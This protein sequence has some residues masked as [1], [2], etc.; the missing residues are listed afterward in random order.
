MLLDGQ[1]AA[2]V[3]IGSDDLTTFQGKL[4]EELAD[5]GN[6]NLINDLP[7]VSGQCGSSLE[8]VALRQQAHDI[9]AVATDT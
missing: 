9:V 4:R 2:L 7:T 8:R 5:E 3:E 1:V 6:R